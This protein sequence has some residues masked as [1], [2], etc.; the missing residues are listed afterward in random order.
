MKT[1]TT[2]EH[3]WKLRDKCNQGKHKLRDNNLGVTWCVVC[4]F[5]SLKPCGTP[6]TEEDKIITT[7]L[8]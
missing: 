1:V 3:Y 5:Q 6:L 2:K 4:G 8:L 7:V